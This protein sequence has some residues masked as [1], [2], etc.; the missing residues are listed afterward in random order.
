MRRICFIA[1]LLVILLQGP[2]MGPMGRPLPPRHV[3]PGGGGTGCAAWP[4]GDVASSHQFPG[5][6]LPDA[7]S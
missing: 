2:A 1:F 7:R 3:H 5:G 4:A 6:S